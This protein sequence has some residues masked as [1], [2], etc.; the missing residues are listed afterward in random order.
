M[1][2]D[3]N[4]TNRLLF[5][6]YT[7]CEAAIKQIGEHYGHHP[8]EFLETHESGGNR[9]EEITQPKFGVHPE[10]SNLRLLGRLDKYLGSLE[11]DCGK[12][13]HAPGIKAL[14]GVAKLILN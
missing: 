4:E 10:W 8:E 9:W 2:T 12:G 6:F 13:Q 14:R 11:A 3:N 1:N 7:L 5:H